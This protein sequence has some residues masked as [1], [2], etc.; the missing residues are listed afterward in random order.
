MGKWEKNGKGVRNDPFRYF[1]SS[2]LDS[3]RSAPL[4]ARMES[5]KVSDKPKKAKPTAKPKAA[6]LASRATSVS[7]GTGSV[8]PALGGAA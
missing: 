8:A 5:V 6:K 4:G 7:A 1:R 3:R 2:E